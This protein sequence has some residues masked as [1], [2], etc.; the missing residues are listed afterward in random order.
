[1]KKGKDSLNAF[2]IIEMALKIYSLYGL[3]ERKKYDLKD[4][5]R[6]FDCLSV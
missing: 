4:K 2:D 5:R 1:M 6:L 3:Y